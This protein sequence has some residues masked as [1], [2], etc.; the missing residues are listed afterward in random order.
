MKEPSAGGRLFSI[1]SHIIPHGL[2]ASIRH[3]TIFI[4]IQA[5]FAG[6]PVA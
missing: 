6:T 1:L 4:R 2:D 5:F 3:A